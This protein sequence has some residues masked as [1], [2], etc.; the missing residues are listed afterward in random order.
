MAGNS[1]HTPAPASRECRCE[2]RVETMHPARRLRGLTMTDKS[3]IQVGTTLFGGQHR[4]YAKG[5][6]QLPR[7]Q[8]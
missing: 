2:G 8:E 1:T 5:I 7:Q 6:D 4:A 3:S